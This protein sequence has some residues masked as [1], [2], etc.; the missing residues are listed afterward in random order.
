MWTLL[1]IAAAALTSGVLLGA[2]I[3]ETVVVDPV[4]PKRPGIVQARNGGLSRQR[5]WLPAHTMCEV[6]LIL[7]L[8]TAWDRPDVRLALLVA[9]IAHAAV[10]VWSLLDVEPAG[11]AFERSDPAGVDEAAAV[12][13]T[14]RSAARLPLDL[15]TCGAVLWALALA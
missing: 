6:L 10:R 1:L 9:V 7:A 3:Y 4:W 13:W 12:R 15:I 14:R 11:R 8:I 5:F 2:G